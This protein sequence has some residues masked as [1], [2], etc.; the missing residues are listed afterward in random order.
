LA[1]LVKRIDKELAAN[2]ALRSYVVVLTDD[3]DATE[4]DLEKMYKSEKLSKVPLTTFEGMAGPKNYKINKDADVSVHLWVKRKVK[5]SFALKSADLNSEKIDEIA[6]A[7][8]DLA[9]KSE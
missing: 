1:S 6:K 8:K 9:P 7:I 3:A 4:K 2:E 5:S